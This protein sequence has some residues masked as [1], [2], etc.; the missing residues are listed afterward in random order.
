METAV[1]ASCALAALAFTLLRFLQRHAEVRHIKAITD[2]LTAQRKHALRILPATRLLSSQWLREW[3]NPKGA[4]RYEVLYQDGMHEQYLVVYRVNLSG[5]VS[6]DWEDQAPS[7][8][9]GG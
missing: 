7:W 4:F 9:Q 8:S 2:L 5:H 1:L 3:G 6:T